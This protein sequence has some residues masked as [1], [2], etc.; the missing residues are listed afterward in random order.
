VDVNF[1]YRSVECGLFRILYF[2]CFVSC[3][4]YFYVCIFF[5]H[6]LSFFY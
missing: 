3:S 1:T 6:R 2:V 4:C 5:S